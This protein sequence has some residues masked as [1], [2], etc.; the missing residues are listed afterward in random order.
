MVGDERGDAEALRARHTFDAPDAVVHGDEEVGLALR[1]E[2]HQFRR[3]P[4][5]ELEAVGHQ[6][7]DVAAE[8]AQRANADGARGGAV[9]V[10]VGD[11]EQALALRD[12]VSEESRGAR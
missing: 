3:E 6:V 1:R 9:G 2:L 11:D 10:V 7:L 4:V 5:A 12:G 8:R